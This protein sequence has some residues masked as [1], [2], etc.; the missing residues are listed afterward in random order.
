MLIG[1]KDDTRNES[2]V[3]GIAVTI[4]IFH[5]IEISQN[6]SDMLK[7]IE[8]GLYRAKAHF[9]TQFAEYHQM[10]TT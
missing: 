7:I 5:T 10:L 3:F 9:C 2:A 1:R 8:R 6:I 4:E